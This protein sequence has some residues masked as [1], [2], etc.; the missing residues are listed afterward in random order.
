MTQLNCFFW[1]LLVSCRSPSDT[2]FSQTA[3]PV[4]VLSP[5]SWRWVH[6]VFYRI[7]FPKE[8]ADQPRWGHIKAV[9]WKV[10]RVIAWWKE[11]LTIQSDKMYDWILNNL[12][13]SHYLIDWLVFANLTEYSADVVFPVFLDSKHAAKYLEMNV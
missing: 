4:G 8:K 5:V 9:R 10:L 11:Q 7:A 12:G 13:I 2:Q 3:T 1:N 6:V